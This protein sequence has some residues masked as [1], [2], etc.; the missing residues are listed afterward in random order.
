MPVGQ[1]IVL[2]AFFVYRTITEEVL[3]MHC[4]RAIKQKFLDNSRNKNGG[5]FYDKFK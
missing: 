2:Q 4:H 1:Y 3:F 5:N